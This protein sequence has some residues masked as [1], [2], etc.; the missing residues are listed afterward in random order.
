MKD[1]NPEEEQYIGPPKVIFIIPFAMASA[2]KSFTWQ[3][4]KESLKNCE[5]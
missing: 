4:I 1:E 5:F 2:G 3:K